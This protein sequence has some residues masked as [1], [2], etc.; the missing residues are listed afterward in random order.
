M[1]LSHNNEAVRTFKKIR[2][3]AKT[4]LSLLFAAFLLCTG[5][6]TYAQN[7]FACISLN[8]LIN[9][10]PETKK[11]D[12]ALVQYQ[13]ALQQEFDDMK[14]DY[15]TQATELSSRDTVKFTIGQLEVKR[16]DLADLL[17]KIQGFDQEASNLLSQKRS[18]LFAPIQRKAMDAINQVAQADKYTYVF[19]KESLQVFPPSTDIL[20][21]V[22]KKLGLPVAS[23]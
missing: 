14:S 21:Q 2:H 5:V 23:R 10:M 4:I 19:Q 16:Q 22:E 13:A 9:A 6:P 8:E 3:M 1:H 17:K 12:T 20:P 15:T 11:A 7:K 18:D